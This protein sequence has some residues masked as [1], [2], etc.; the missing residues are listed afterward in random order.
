MLTWLPWGWGPEI[1][2]GWGPEILAGPLI[3]ASVTVVD[4][5]NPPD[6]QK[7]LKI[8]LIIGLKVP[9]NRGRP[10]GTMWFWPFL[11]FWTF[12]WQI[13]MLVKRNEGYFSA[14]THLIFDQK[15][16]FLNTYLGLFLTQKHSNFG[17]KSRKNSRFWPLPRG[18]ACNFFRFLDVFWRFWRFFDVFLSVPGVGFGGPRGG[19]VGRFG[20]A[21][22]VR[23]YANTRCEHRGVNILR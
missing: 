17:H 22:E 18:F 20:S 23:S 14:K 1:V 11:A 15:R 19:G 3:K 16:D 21:R 12:F 6:L 9:K 7:P 13:V 10:W 8:P 4:L 2:P 5:Q